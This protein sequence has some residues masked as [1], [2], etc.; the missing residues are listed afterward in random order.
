MISNLSNL[1]ALAESYPG[2]H[3]ITEMSLR[4][5]D[6][7]LE[8]DDDYLE[9]NEQD[10]LGLMCVKCLEEDLCI[11]GRAAIEGG[12][13]DD[14]DGKY[15]ATQEFSEEDVKTYIEK[16]SPLTIDAVVKFIKGKSK[17]VNIEI[18]LND[19]T[20]VKSYRIDEANKAVIL[21]GYH[22]QI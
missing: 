14:F 17:K 8:D 18:D 20:D 9:E 21:K 11:D 16:N 10:S 6:H 1:K 19:Y 3:L 22:T 5:D 12:H 7:Y 4:G 15:N 13:Y 2:Y